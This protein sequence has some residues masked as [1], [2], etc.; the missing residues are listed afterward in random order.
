ME[1]SANQAHCVLHP[2]AAEASLRGRGGRGV[3][4]DPGVGQVQ[5]LH[6]VWPGLKAQDE[7]VCG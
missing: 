5:H 6:E 1:R 2:E 3:C 7:A 4:E